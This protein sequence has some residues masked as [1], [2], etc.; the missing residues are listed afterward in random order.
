MTR[1][2]CDDGDPFCLLLLPASS[3][4]KEVGNELL[5][6]GRP[7]DTITGDLWRMLS[8]KG[9]IVGFLLHREGA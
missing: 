2:T 8:E 4:S 9:V 5:K 3:T 1:E 6:M 7:E